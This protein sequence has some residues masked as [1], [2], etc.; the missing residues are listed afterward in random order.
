VGC[1]EALPKD[2]SKLEFPVPKNMTFYEEK[3]VCRYNSMKTLK[4]KL[5]WVK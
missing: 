4:M 1:L 5:L 2:I 3:G